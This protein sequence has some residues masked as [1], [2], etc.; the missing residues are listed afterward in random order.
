MMITSKLI[1]AS[2]SESDR[3][4]L[5]HNCRFTNYAGGY[6]DRRCQLKPRCSNH[7]AL[8]RKFRG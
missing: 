2:F 8:L 7:L 4:I 6:F 5:G 3:A 1:R